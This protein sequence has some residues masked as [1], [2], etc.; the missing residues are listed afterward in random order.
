MR[1]VG[2]MEN[3]LPTLMEGYERATDVIS[4]QGMRI[5]QLR[6][7]DPVILFNIASRSRSE[8]C[9]NLIYNILDLTHAHGGDPD[10]RFVLKTDTDDTDGGY[11]WASW[12]ER[13]NSSSQNKIHAINR[14]IPT[15]HWDIIVDVSDDFVFTREN[16]D[17]IIKDHCGPDDCLHFPEPFATSQSEKA[18]NENIIIMACMGR[19]YYDRFG[20]IYN[21]E[22]KSLFCD[23]ELT[24]VAKKLGRYKFVDESIFYHAHPAAGYGKADAQ[25]QHT[26]SFW[27]EDKA[28]YYR[29]KE[30]GFP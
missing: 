1:G 25:T 20:Y 4:K 6:A 13:F 2:D 11:L 19:K 17:L 18:K 28:T 15:D 3:S 7:K 10:I 9:R 16:F 24:A 23:N 22:Y 12:I 27:K 14:D 26:E 21:P 30:A 29:R 8:K 5:K